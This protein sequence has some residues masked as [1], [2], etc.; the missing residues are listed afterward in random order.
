MEYTA[1]IKY[2]YTDADALPEGAEAN[3]LYIFSDYYT[4][5][6]NRHDDAS[7]RAYIRRDLRLV[8]GGGYEPINNDNIR[9]IKITREK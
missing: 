9:S 2:E 6:G 1:T 8:A 3:K 5:D 4:V 7:A